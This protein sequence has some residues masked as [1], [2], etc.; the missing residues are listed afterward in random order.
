MR[1]RRADPRADHCSAARAVA[2]HPVA[3]SAPRLP[4]GAGTGRRALAGS[5]GWPWSRPA[6]PAIRHARPSLRGVI[7]RRRWC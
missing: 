7:L 2:G 1:L 3:P 5:P 4:A 6:T